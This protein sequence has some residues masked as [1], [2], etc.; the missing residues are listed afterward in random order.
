MFRFI[1]SFVHFI[2]NLFKRPYS[3]EKNS[4][5]LEVSEFF[6]LFA[7]FDTG[8]KLIRIG[9]GGDG[10][11]LIPEDIVNISGCF[12]PGVGSTSAF[13]ND[14]ANRFN[15][16]SWLLDDSVSSPAD[17]H[18]LNSFKK[19]KLG[20]DTI[21]NS[22]ITLEDWVSESTNL[23]DTDFILQM[24]IE[25]HEWQILLSAQLDLLSRFRIM[26]IEFHS[27]PL[28]RIPYV[29]DRVYLPTVKKLLLNFDVVHIHPNNSVGTFEHSGI[30]YPDTI[31][32]T[33]L[34]KDRRLKYIRL[35]SV[36]NVLDS[37]C[38]PSKVEIVIDQIVI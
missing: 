9:L 37:P 35:N 1:R 11:Y 31:E 33:F 15:I 3:L 34:R 32:V 18:V 4:S 8:H 5:S 27:L 14:L 28:V 12:S 6:R 26:V 29:L 24:D 21:P 25:S 38:D 19:L 16:R 20:L 23:V 2:S 22:S 36:R 13:E 10:G 7:P 30:E 17:L